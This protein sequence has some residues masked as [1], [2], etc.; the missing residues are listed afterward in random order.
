MGAL[1]RT[2]T[3]VRARSRRSSAQTPLC[4]ASHQ[5]RTIIWA[6]FFSTSCSN[7]HVFY[8]HSI[9]IYSFAFREYTAKE[10]RIS[11]LFSSPFLLLSFAF[12]CK[13]ILVGSE[14]VDGGNMDTGT[15]IFKTM[16]NKNAHKLKRI[17]GNC[18]ENI[19]GGILHIFAITIA[20]FIGARPMERGVLDPLDRQSAPAPPPPPNTDTHNGEIQAPK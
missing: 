11:H 14:M 6:W 3:L 18:H 2:R 7:R 16:T 1:Q 20:D 8:A 19:S 4:L 12:I 17:G 13:T 15:G 10:L 5:L 9:A